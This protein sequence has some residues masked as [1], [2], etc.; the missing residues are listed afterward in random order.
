[1]G[2]RRN[3]SNDEVDRIIAMYNDGEPIEVIMDELGCSYTL[4]NKVLKENNLGIRKRNTLKNCNYLKNSTKYN[5]NEDYFKVID[6]PNKAYWLGFIY[7]DGYVS[8]QYSKN[9]NKKNARFELNLSYLDREHIIKFLNDISANYPI[10]DR[11]I[12]GKE[13][14]RVC[15]SRMMFVDNLVDNGCFPAKT[16]I[17]KPPNIPSELIPHFIRG[18]F[19]GDGCAYINLEKRNY[20]FS[21]TGT[22]EILEFIKEQSGISK[23]INV[24]KITNENA[25]SL[26]IHG[27]QSIIMFF[28]YIYNNKTVYLERKWDKSLQII[29]FLIKGEQKD[30]FKNI[31]EA[32]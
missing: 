16:Y 18:Y 23:N 29:N 8:Y 31:E 1:M 11:Q 13:S 19:D 15:I 4:L 20:S 22:K 6:T 14:S 17:L 5:V 10:V 25:Y 21:I 7:A 12:N 26:N 2:T 27:K 32:S 28:D 3:F 9:G 24:N 30:E